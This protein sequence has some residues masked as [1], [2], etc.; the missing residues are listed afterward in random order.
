MQPDPNIR[1]YIKIGIKVRNQSDLQLL[2]KILANNNNNEKH[3]AK[4]II[5]KETKTDSNWKLVTEGVATPEYGRYYYYY[6]IE[7]MN[8]K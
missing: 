6:C 7:K 4:I 1:D 2:I 8:S 5:R 3:K